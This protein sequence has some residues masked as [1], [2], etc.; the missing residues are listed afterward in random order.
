M[1]NQP[2]D[3][4]SSIGV[5][6]HWNRGEPQP[7]GLIAWVG[8]LSDRQSH[9]IPW[10][11]LPG[12]ARSQILDLVKYAGFRFGETQPGDADQLLLPLGEF[13]QPSR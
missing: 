4:P 3:S 13:V 6:V 8:P 1:K 7:I 10:S 9:L 5:S 11:V 12:R 2:G